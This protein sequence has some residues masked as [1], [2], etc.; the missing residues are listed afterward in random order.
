MGALQDIEIQG[1][2]ADS[3]TVGR[4]FLFAALAGTHADGRA[5]VDDAVARGAVAVLAP[6]GTTLK[7]YDPPV[8][9]IT[10]ENPRRRLA[11]MAARFHGPQPEVVAAVTG[12]SGKTSVA[13]FLRQI[14]AHAGHNAAS[15]GT[16]G[17]EPARAD[18]PSSLTTPDPVELHRCLSALTNDGVDR[19]V[20]E[21]SSHGLDQ[22]RLDGVRVAAAAFTN[23]S[24][25]HLDY[26]RD[27]AAYRNAKLRLFSELLRS[28]GTAVINADDP[29]GAEFRKACTARGIEVL[30]YGTAESDLRLLDRTPTAE[31]QSLRFE[32]RDR[33]V[34]MTLPVAGTFQAVNALA[35]LGLALATGVD[36][37]A[38]VE[39][40]SHLT[41]VPGRLEF[42][43]RSPNGGAVYVDYAHKPAALEA[44][45]QALRPHTQ[46]KLWAL[47]GAGGDRD[48]GK[49]PMMGAAAERL[50]DRVV[51]TDDNPRSEDPAVIR[52]A[53]LAAA[54]DAKEIGDRGEAIAWAMAALGP[55]DVLVIAGKGH[56]S[57]QIVGDRV[58]PFDDRDVAR[59]ALA[60][61]GSDTGSQRTA[62]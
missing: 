30:S 54:P 9:L 16:L 59:A 57:G 20:M 12:T 23:L 11:L 44:V 8:R 40:L 43:G 41:G 52:K 22:Y 18:A 33:S 60:D 4:G 45:L 42:I 29:V 24:R 7:A 37:A 1:L 28:G 27:M 2:S 56:E 61:L 50:A 55:G 48:P 34:D 35:A 36:E 25:D 32:L 51:V 31:G 14:W 39:A 47:F 6:A 13:S 15:L 5:F 21:A 53:I 26:H 58:L 19:L 17:L 3:R 46:A 62:E 49:R 10:D 38:A